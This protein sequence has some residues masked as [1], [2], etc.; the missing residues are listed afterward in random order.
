MSDIPDSAIIIGGLGIIMGLVGVMHGQVMTKLEQL[1][2]SN[3]EIKE[4]MAIH[5]T[6]LEVMSKEFARIE[7]HQKIQDGKIHEIHNQL[8][9][10]E[11]RIAQ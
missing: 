10:L 1:V 8:I 7:E 11:N 2:K 6:K 5:N 9:A 3:G 4:V